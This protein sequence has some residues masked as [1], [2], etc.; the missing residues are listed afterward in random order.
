[1]MV[2]YVGLDVSQEETSFCVKSAKG[3][4]LAQGKALSDPGSLFDSLRANCT[5]PEL[6]VMEKGNS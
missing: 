6:I 5:C 2:E 3:K 4:I 1:M